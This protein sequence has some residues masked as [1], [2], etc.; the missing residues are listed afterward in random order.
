MLHA[1]S[2]PAFGMTFLLIAAAL[3]PSV[4]QQRAAAD[5]WG[6]PPSAA[7]SAAAPRDPPGAPAKERLGEKWMDDQRVD[8]CKVPPDK[9]GPKPR[10]D[11][12]SNVLTG[13]SPRER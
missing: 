4:A 13:L 2:R 1:F 12:C 6:A 9:R 11:S 5:A 7:T 10:P 3:S 8:N